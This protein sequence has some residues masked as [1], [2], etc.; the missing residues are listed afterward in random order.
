MPPAYNFKNLSAYYTTKRA[1]EG[2]IV[3][4]CIILV[5]VQAITRQLKTRAAALG[6]NRIGLIPAAPARRLSAYLAWIEAGYQGTMAYMARSDRIERR[7]D[8]QVILP[9]VQTIISVGLDYS[10]MAMPQDIAN[11]PSRGRISAYAWGSDYHD[12]MIPRLKQLVSWLHQMDSEAQSCVYVDTGAILERDHAAS[13]GLGFTGKNSMLIAPRGGCYFFL[14]EILTTLPLRD[15]QLRRI[16]PGCGTCS[17]C[18]DN[19]PTQAFPAPY[20]LDSR[21]CISYL[22]IELKE[23]IPVELREAMGNWVYGCDV[24]QEVCPF[25]R[26]TQAAH[27]AAFWPEAWDVAAPPLVDLLELD[28]ENFG[29]RFAGSPIKRIKR[30]RLVRNACIAAGNWG[31]AEAVPSLIPLLIDAEPLV[32]GHAAWALRKIG[33]EE[34]RRAIQ[35]ALLGEQEEMVRREMAGF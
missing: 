15:E 1:S 32:R 9:G 35:D 29:R 25:N 28:E 17:R 12:L 14:G 34:A 3:K 21:R 16:M 6:F 19:C 27:E 20:I 4:P 5:T 33:T 10:T 18:L 24:C 11:D 23:W 30:R 2:S 22:T 7:L 26:F 31:S 13:G 8:P